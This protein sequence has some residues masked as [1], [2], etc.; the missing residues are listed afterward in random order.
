MLLLSNVPGLLADFTDEGS[1][2]AEIPHGEVESYLEVA[3]GRMK[4]KVLGASEA[5]AGGVGRV[6]FG[7]ARAAKPV[8]RAL[9]GEGTVVR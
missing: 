5:V 7:D 2:I 6:V 9:A 4:K 1:L 3:Q 8:T